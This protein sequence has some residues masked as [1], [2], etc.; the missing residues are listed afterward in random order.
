MVDSQ[1]RNSAVQPTKRWWRSKTLREIYE[2]PMAAKV[3]RTHSLVV[4]VAN[5][6][7]C[8]YGANGNG[9]IRRNA[10]SQYR[11]VTDMAIAECINNL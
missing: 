6:W 5:P 9:K 10:R 1:V 3:C 11:I 4:C 8:T 2:S 7:E